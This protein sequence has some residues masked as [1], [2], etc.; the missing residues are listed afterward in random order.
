VVNSSL[1]SLSG[2]TARS[3]RAFALLRSAAAGYACPTP[4]MGMPSSE[5]DST[6]IRFPVTVPARACLP[7]EMPF[8]FATKPATRSY[9][10]ISA[11]SF[12]P[13]DIVY[14]ESNVSGPVCS[15]SHRCQFVCA[16]PHTGHTLY[17]SGHTG[18]AESVAPLELRVNTSSQRLHTLCK[19]GSSCSQHTNVSWR[20]DCP[21][22]RRGLGQTAQTLTL[23]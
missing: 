14:C 3:F 11:A 18:H 7:S 4:A 8:A 9:S 6:A 20:R 13:S 2:W 16:P 10:T 12:L 21:C 17:V 15:A 23:A 19:T 22:S 1:R 5:R